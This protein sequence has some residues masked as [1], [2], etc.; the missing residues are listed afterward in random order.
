M[1]DGI[2]LQQFMFLWEGGGDRLNWFARFSKIKIINIYKRLFKKTANWKKKIR[3]ETE[4]N[5][6]SHLTLH[7]KCI[8]VTRLQ[9]GIT[10]IFF[11]I[12]WRSKLKGLVY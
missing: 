3:V 1:H 5:F 12:M 2:Y 11:E 6:R 10:F 7:L 4:Q 8:I 9:I